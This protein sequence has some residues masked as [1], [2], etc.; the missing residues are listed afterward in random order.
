[1]ITVEALTKTYGSLK[2][3]S[4]LSFS[5]LPNELIGFIGPNGSGKTT[6][7]KCLSTLIKPTSGRIVM[8]GLDLSTH[9]SEAREKIGY[10]P[11]ENSLLLDLTVEEYLKFRYALKKSGPH[12]ATPDAVLRLCGLEN[13]EKKVLRNLSKGYKQRVGIAESLLGTP[14]V[15]FLDEPINGLDPDQIMHI[16][17]LLVSLKSTHT[18]VVSSHILSELELT[19]DKYLIISKGKMKAFGTLE[20]LMKKSVTALSYRFEF[21]TSPS[22]EV[23]SG[24]QGMDGIKELFLEG[25][26][27]SVITELE[28]RDPRENIQKRAF[29]KGFY[30]SGMEMKIKNLEEIYKDLTRE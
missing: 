28:A 30:L 10:L 18:L 14:K 22:P 21:F 25:K 7:F 11:E 9:F 12:A 8:D 17:S 2:A 3:V 6:T 16:R 20:E 15:L 4:D 5:I 29:E 26:V 24:F 19:C 13:T 27:L 1:M 23:F